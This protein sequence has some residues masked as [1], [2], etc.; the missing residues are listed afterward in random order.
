[1]CVEE[2]KKKTNHATAVGIMGTRSQ[3]GIFSLTRRAHP[4]VSTIDYIIIRYVSSTTGTIQTIRVIISRAYLKYNSTGTNHTSPVTN[5]SV[6]RMTYNIVPGILLEK[7]T[8]H[9]RNKILCMCGEG[10]FVLNDSFPVWCVREN[11]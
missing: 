4:D 9:D 5:V 11:G 6:K 8:A 3:G 2:K 7:Y 10:E 1:M